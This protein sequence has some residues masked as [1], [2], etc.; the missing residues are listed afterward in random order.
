[1]GVAQTNLDL[2][3]FYIAQDKLDLAKS[4]IQ[5][6]ESLIEEHKLID[7]ENDLSAIKHR[8]AQR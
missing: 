6:S 1:M 2:A 7:I 4:S 5:I 3:E 8:L